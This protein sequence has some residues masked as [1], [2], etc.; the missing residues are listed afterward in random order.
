[1]S[2]SQALVIEY[3][4]MV[5][6]AF[7]QE[8]SV[9]N[10]KVTIDTGAGTQTA[11]SVM[12]PMGVQDV[13]GS[14]A[15]QTVWQNPD[16]YLRWAPHLMKHFAVML[17]QYDDISAF[18]DLRR[19]Y[20]QAGVGGHNRQI[21]R[22]LAQAATGAATQ[23][24]PP[25]SVA[26]AT[27]DTAA[28][29]NDGTGGNLI[30]AGG[31]GMT[32]AKLKTALG[33]LLMR[34][35]GVGRRGELG[36]DGYVAMMTGYQMKQ[37]LDATDVTSWDFIGN[38]G[39]NNAPLVK[40]FV[41]RYAGFDIIL[42]DPS[43][44]DVPAAATRRCLAWHRSAMGL[45]LWPGSSAAGNAAGAAGSATTAN[46]YITIDRL[47]EHQNATGAQISAHY[48]AVRLQDKGVLA[49]DCVE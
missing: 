20:I 25:G 19:P 31:T 36:P 7:Q 35:V 1:M 3:A 24:Q 27:F 21:D 23:G 11:F 34:S 10:D 48:G 15:S 8:M 42:T 47:P 32:P 45:A 22:T 41:A 26:A 28:P 46:F 17:S 13:T 6:H 18:T 5:Q 30:A 2:V 43:V 29:N 33:T 12:N 38:L 49:I 39:P 37:L 4:D 40:G 9:L 14:P 44:L 16:L